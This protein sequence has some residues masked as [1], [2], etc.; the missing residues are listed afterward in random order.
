MRRSGVP[1]AAWDAVAT[2]GGRVSVPRP[3]CLATATVA[4]LP[5]GAGGT[6]GRAGAEA[7]ALSRSSA[8][9]LGPDMLPAAPSRSAPGSGSADR[10]ATTWIAGQT[11]DHRP[12]GAVVLDGRSP[13]AGDCLGLPPAAPDRGCGSVA[14]GEAAWRKTVDV[15]RPVPPTPTTVGRARDGSSPVRRLSIPGRDHRRIAVGA[16]PRGRSLRRVGAGHGA[17]RIEVIGAAP[18]TGTASGADSMKVS[19]SIGKNIE[20]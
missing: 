13:P 18:L 14:D 8:G 7:G 5:A 6:D 10:D 11:R 3:P 16:R 9:D 19:L 4:A 12:R 15:Q 2:G 20:T 17:R 1:S